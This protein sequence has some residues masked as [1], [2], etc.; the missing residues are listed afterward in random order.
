MIKNL[1]SQ[2]ISNKQQSS[3]TPHQVETTTQQDTTPEH[4]TL[5]RLLLEP[6]ISNAIADYNNSVTEAERLQIEFNNTQQ[7]LQQLSEKL[8][9][10]QSLLPTLERKRGEL[11][12]DIEE[13]IKL[14]EEIKRLPLEIAAI[15]QAIKNVNTTDSAQYKAAKELTE[16]N[17]KAYRAKRRLFS[18]IQAT[19]QEQ[20]KAVSG[21]LW[22]IW[23]AF[24]G[25]DG[26]LDKANTDISGYYSN[27]SNAENMRAELSSMIDINTV[28]D[29]DLANRI[30]VIADDNA[31]LERI[32][33]Q[34]GG[35]HKFSNKLPDGSYI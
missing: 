5:E 28:F 8:Q 15:S 29:N 14:E 12:G 22:A 4:T 11:G 21:D 9:H 23:W 3:T 32:K 16:A 20:I 2:I 13:L 17:K 34:H 27:R 19:A 18:L 7:E 24:G 25:N 1:L 10:K 35:I 30:I 6:I 26:A 33:K 31:E